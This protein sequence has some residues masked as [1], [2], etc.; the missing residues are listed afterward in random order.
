M[1]MSWNLIVMNFYVLSFKI[2]ICALESFEFVLNEVEQRGSKGN[3]RRLKTKQKTMTWQHFQAKAWSDQ[4]C[5][6]LM[7]WL[8]ISFPLTNPI[9]TRRSSLITDRG[10]KIKTW[11]K[12]SQLFALKVFS[13][14][15]RRFRRWSPAVATTCPP[16]RRWLTGY[17]RS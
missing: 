7:T 15:R 14:W 8:H 3:F 2:L 5:I 16:R 6:I 10:A 13:F 17:R 12:T 11:R 1:S 4:I 9:Y